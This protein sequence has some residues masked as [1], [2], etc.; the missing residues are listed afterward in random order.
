MGARSLHCSQ[1]WRACLR[2]KPAE[3]D[4]RKGIF[5]AG[6]SSGFLSWLLSR[7][8]QCVSFSFNKASILSSFSVTVT[9]E[10]LITTSF[11]T[12][13]PDFSEKVGKAY[14]VAPPPSPSK[15]LIVDRSK[16]GCCHK[17]RRDHS[18]GHHA[19]AASRD[20]RGKKESGM[21]SGL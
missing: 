18:C 5:R 17:R 3:G 21:A 7:T 16:S 15:E 6:V 14:G 12:A 11:P 4:R 1:D 9:Q 19:L 8:S 20:V 10:I 2:M 13:V